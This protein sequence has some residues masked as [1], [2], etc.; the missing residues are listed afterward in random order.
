MT[1]GRQRHRSARSH[2]RAE[3]P[4]SRRCQGAAPWAR[5]TQSCDALAIAQAAL[6]AWI[7]IALAAIAA[8][9]L[10]RWLGLI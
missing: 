9:E 4:P 3:V 10:G 5:S 7:A 8:V 6:V 1:A 2:P